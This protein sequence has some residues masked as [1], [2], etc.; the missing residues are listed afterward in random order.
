MIH[1]HGTPISP[2]H[3]LHTLA[4]RH[5]CVSHAAPRDVATCHQIGQGV[6]L[7]N[8]AYSTWRRGLCPDWVG[9]YAW[10]WEWLAWP[11]TWAIIPDVIDGGEDA[12][13]ALLSQWPHGERGAPVWHMHESLTRLDR[14]AQA[15]P[16]VCVGSS[17]A[18]AVI[19]SAAWTTR[20]HQAWDV[21]APGG[22][23]L[24]WVH[25]LRAMEAANAGPWPFA[26]TDSCNLARNHS[27]RRAHAQAIAARLDA[28][29]P[30]GL[31]DNPGVQLDLAI[32]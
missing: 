17:G 5:F 30:P 31:W 6:L 22:R 4:G 14:L 28:S 19:G 26:S 15:W 21:L 3:V 12:N 7:D 9:Y 10:A 29:Q 20:L 23:P 16:R 1:Y 27:Q 8:G 2:R 32:G 24:L 13:D 25:M 18:Y 11:T